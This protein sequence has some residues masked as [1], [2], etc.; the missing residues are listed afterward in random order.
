MDVTHP[1]VFTVPLVLMVLAHILQL[2][3]YSQRLKNT[4]YLSSFFGFVLTFS[5]PWIVPWMP[6]GAVLI[7]LGGMLL[8]LSGSLLCLLPLRELLRGKPRSA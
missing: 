5:V 3:H 6:H 8:L 7:P 4:L 2:C 1:H